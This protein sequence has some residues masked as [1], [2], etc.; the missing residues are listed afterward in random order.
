MRAALT[1]WL[2]VFAAACGS[3]GAQKANDPNVVAVGKTSGQAPGASAPPP[4]DARGATL[5]AEHAEGLRI[6]ERCFTGASPDTKAALEKVLALGPDKPLGADALRRDLAAAYA[7]GL[8]DQIEAT[9]RQS[10]TGC[11]LFLAVT[12]RPK[13]SAV[14]FEGLVALKDDPNVAAFPKAGAAL[15]AP[16]IHAASE[17]L[18]TA[19]AAAGWDDAKVEHVVE[20]DGPGKARVKIVVA[21]GAR[22]K[23]GKVTFEGVR[24]G[25]EAGLR[26]AMELPD[27]TPLD[28]ERLMRSIL[29]VAAFYYDNGFMNVKVEEPKRTKAPDGSTTLAFKISEGPVFRIGKLSVSKVDAA[30]QKE[31]LAGLKVKS[32]EIFNRSKLKAD[33]EDLESRSRKNGR[34]LSAEPETKLDAKA[35][36]VDITLAVKER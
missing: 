4:C 28:P 11:A 29:L 15:S 19:Y 30:L 6:V 12:E 22:A 31:V 25:R 13:I 32:G 7:T 3:G 1:G 18:R 23:V 26:K 33:L 8:V 2:V 24:D 27:G 14:A 21:E 10:G 36:I 16:A 20:P 9:A 5:D 17:K 35:G 34:P